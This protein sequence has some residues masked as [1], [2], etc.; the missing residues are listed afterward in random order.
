M[1]ETGK[2]L[3]EVSEAFGDYKIEADNEKKIQ[4]SGTQDTAAQTPKRRERDKLCY[5]N[6]SAYRKV[7]YKREQ[8]NGFIKF[9][10]YR[11]LTQTRKQIGKKLFGALPR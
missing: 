7:P 3:G 4:P 1:E 2:Q 5:R 9:L 11:K 10:P 8:I 6:V